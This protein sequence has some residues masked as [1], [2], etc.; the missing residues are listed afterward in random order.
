MKQL[1]KTCFKEFSSLTLNFA[2]E[3]VNRTIS[4]G[5][6][7][8]GNVFTSTKNIGIYTQSNLFICTGTNS[9]LSYS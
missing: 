5:S 1:G 6:H 8:H 3:K 7:R 4:M 2:S 9:A